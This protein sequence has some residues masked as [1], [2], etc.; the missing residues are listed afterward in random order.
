MKHCSACRRTLPLSHFYKRKEKAGKHGRSGYCKRCSS[1]KLLAW[2]QRNRP[3]VNACA[4]RWRDQHPGY[5]AA[6][7]RA[8]QM[9]LRLEVLTA[10]GRRCAKCGNEDVRVLTIEHKHG[11]GKRHLASAGSAWAILR[12]IKR[13]GFPDSYGV[14]C[15]NCNC[16]HGANPRALKR[17]TVSRRTLGRRER[18]RLVHAHYGGVC[19]H[20]QTDTCLDLDHI[21]GWR[22]S[23]YRGCPRRGGSGTA[24]WIM[25]FGKWHLFQLLCQNCNWIKTL[26]PSPGLPTAPHGGERRSGHLSIP[27]DLQLVPMASLAL[28]ES[29]NDFVKFMRIAE[30]GADFLTISRVSGR[31]ARNA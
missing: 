15:R 1:R 8:F 25:R 31:N 12:R 10:Y 16:V 19:A 27:L 21:F 28:A 7:V 9:A 4:K 6:R 13:E 29:L 2:Q 23:R 17:G 11:G 18:V 20:C 22:D 26:E 24:D 14:L 3:A 5:N 30:V